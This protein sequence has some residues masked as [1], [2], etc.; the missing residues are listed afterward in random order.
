MRIMSSTLIEHPIKGAF[1]LGTT[2]EH[3]TEGLLVVSSLLK[4]DETHPDKYILR[5]MGEPINQFSYVV[6]TLNELVRII[7]NPTLYV[8]PIPEAEQGGWKEPNNGNK[9]VILKKR[10]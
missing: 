1:M 9:K 4:G 5:K 2:I 6:L 10:N 7:Q 3:P 8:E